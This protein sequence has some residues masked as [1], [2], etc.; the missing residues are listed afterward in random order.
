MGTDGLGSRVSSADA[1]V[2][3]HH[4][5]EHRAI[6]LPL[7]GLVVALALTGC[8]GAAATASPTEGATLTQSARLSPTPTLTAT[9]TPSP[10]PVPGFSPT[11]S[12]STPRFGHTA[13]LLPNGHV[14]IAGGADAGFATLATAELYDPATGT[15]SPTGSMSTP[16]FNHTAT[17]LPDG[18]V[19][20]AG[21]S[22]NTSAPLAT[23]ELYDPATGTFSPTGSMTTARA[24]QSATLLPNGLVL[25]A[26]GAAGRASVESVLAT[27]ELYDPATGTFSPTGSMHTPVVRPTATLLPTAGC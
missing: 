19:L 12:M 26:G 22:D 17:L 5:S 27:A 25:I 16:R 14:L 10:T 20:V 18:R 9:P 8:S 1:F 24:A 6:G 3:P 4:T 13:T 2:R 21:G 23:A 7:A 11:G 15:F